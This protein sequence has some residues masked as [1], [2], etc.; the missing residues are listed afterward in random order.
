MLDI[1]TQT[2]RITGNRYSVHQNSVAG[3]EPNIH[4]NNTTFWST[5]SLLGM[6]LR[7]NVVERR[8]QM[9]QAPVLRLSAWVLL[10]GL[11][12][13]PNA[14]PVYLLFPGFKPG[15]YSPIVIQEAS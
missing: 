3:N 7:R 14:S 6:R 9:P 1:K 8:E 12:S 11:S 10:T 13:T 5:H 15:G 2:N 4:Y